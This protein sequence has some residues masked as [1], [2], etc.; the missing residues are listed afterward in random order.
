MRTG[1]YSYKENKGFRKGG[2]GQLRLK[3]QGFCLLHIQASDYR[4][5]VEIDRSGIVA[6]LKRLIRPKEK[7][8]THNDCSQFRAEK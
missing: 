3:I 8:R 4:Q 5:V 7:E 6:K 1:V 2:G